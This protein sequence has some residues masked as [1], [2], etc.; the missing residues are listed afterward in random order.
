M[1]FGV[2]SFSFLDFSEFDADVSLIISNC[3]LYNHQDTPFCRAASLVESCWEK[4]KERYRAKYV[5][6]RAADAAAAAAAAEGREDRA[7]AVGARDEPNQELA[8]VEQQGDIGTMQEGLQ[9]R[10]F[11]F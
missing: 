2:F 11:R 10:A 1:R 7:A 9:L 8:L 4:F 5:A 3:R 6:A